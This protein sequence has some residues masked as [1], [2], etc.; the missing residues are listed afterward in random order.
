MSTREEQAIPYEKQAE[1]RTCGAAA[2]GMV[3][4]SLAAARRERGV[5]PPAVPAQ[6][7]IWEAIG[8]TDPRGNRSCAT[9]LMVK[10]ALSRGYAA[11]ALQASDPLQLLLASRASGV[12]AI[13]NHRLRPDGP[14]GHFTVLVGMDEQG[15]TVHDPSTGPSRKLGFGQL[16]ELW[17]PRHRGSE[18]I[19]NVLIGIADG[20]PR[21]EKCPACSVP[22]P[23]DVPCPQCKAPVP[24]APSSLVAC[25][26]GDCVRRSWI[27]VCCPACD[28]TFPFVGAAEARPPRTGDGIWNLGPLFAELGKFQA[29]IQGMPQVAGREDVKEQLA[30]IDRKKMELRLAEH[31]EIVRAEEERLKTSERDEKL[32]NEAEEIRKA[33]EAATSPAA[34]LDGNALAADLLKSLGIVK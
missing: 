6:A 24:L 16:L 4:Q 7:E 1:G 5:P 17:Q 27:R 34:P 13:L 31:E 21:V 15:V 23:E 11:V 3:Y 2:L 25:V 32:R 33:R 8:R 18:I 14:A 29:Y 10:D 19:G 28:F 26:G 12:H 9:H 22:I 30:L 20:P